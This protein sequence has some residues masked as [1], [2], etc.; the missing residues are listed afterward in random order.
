MSNSQRILLRVHTNRSTPSP[1]DLA[2]GRV[3]LTAVTNG[4]EDTETTEVTTA[5]V[6]L[7]LQ[8]QDGSATRISVYQ[9]E[10]EW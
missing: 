10:P 8:V 3:S 2:P 5:P 1:Y 4:Q 7:V 6:W 9:R